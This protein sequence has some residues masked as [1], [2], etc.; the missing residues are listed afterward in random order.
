MTRTP[1]ESRVES[2]FEIKREREQLRTALARGEFEATLTHIRDSRNGDEAQLRH[3]HFG[4][5]VDSISVGSEGET[6]KTY[7]FHGKAPEEERKH[8]QDIM[9][10]P[11]HSGIALALDAMNALRYDPGA[12]KDQTAPEHFSQVN[13]PL[14]ANT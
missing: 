14:S 13:R 5:V 10:D 7:H 3:M 1:E 12:K 2:K 9:A 6:R 4:F 8:M 11:D